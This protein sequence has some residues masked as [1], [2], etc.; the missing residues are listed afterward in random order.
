M[1]AELGAPVI[2]TDIIARELVL[3]GQPALEEIRHRFGDAVIDANGCL[4]RSAMRQLIFA[5]PVARRD[6]EAIL[7]PR[8]G[9][10][11]RRQAET[12][13]G[14]YQVIVV[15]LLLTSPL[16][17]FVDRILV[18]D[19]DEQTQIKRLLARDAESETQAHRMLAAQTRRDE[20]LACAD[21]I[22]ENNAELA[23][24]RR[25]VNRLHRKY[26]R[27]AHRQGRS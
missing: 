14:I 5:D 18:V 9:D 20:R 2:D 15:P 11:T 25:A 24:T 8:I 1:F 10:E 13:G 27:L 21:D 3:P 16:R 19:C 4:D 17:G 6:L 7:H 12:A 23:T 22:I 26:L